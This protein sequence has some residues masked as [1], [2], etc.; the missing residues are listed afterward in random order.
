MLEVL[1]FI[2]VIVV[3]NRLMEKVG[4]HKKHTEYWRINTEYSMFLISVV[5]SMVIAQIIY[6]TG[7]KK[8]ETIEPRIIFEFFPI[9]YML[10]LNH[11]TFR[12]I[13]KLSEP[14]PPPRNTQSIR[15]SGYDVLVRYSQMSLIASSYL[16]KPIDNSS[17]QS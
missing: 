12:S 8:S 10:W 16:C 9:A 5:L 6:F 15:K 7:H 2:Y 13:G 11:C 3:L 14:A 4:I 17:S 1:V